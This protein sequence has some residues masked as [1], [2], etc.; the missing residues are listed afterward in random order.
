[1]ISKEKFAAIKLALSENVGPITYRQIISYFKN[2]QAAI[3]NFSDFSSKR[4][5]LIKLASD[6]AVHQQLDMAEKLGAQLLVINTPEYPKLLSHI[7]DAPPILYAFGNT[8]LFERKCIS[9]VGSR[10]AS[11]NGLNLARKIS[12]DLTEAEM[13]VV[14]GMAKGID[15]AAHEGSLHSKINKAGTI[16]VLGTGVDVVYPRENKDIYEEIK[17][18]GLILSEMPF[19]SK[20]ITSAFPR[21][22]RIISGLTLGTLVV[23]ASRMSG[24]LITAREALSQSREVFAIP[25]SPLD[26]RAS[27]PNQLIKDGAHLVSSAEDILSILNSN[28]IL[29][30]ADS[31]ARTSDVGFARLMRNDDEFEKAKQQILNHLSPQV[32]SI[33]S[34]I[35]GTDLDSDLVQAVLI[36]LELSG[37]IERFSGNRIALLY[38]NEWA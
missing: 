16:A 33:T 26:S 5:R 1:M 15:R 12:Y 9:I 18:K 27:G 8:T 23:E 2:A 38:N 32:T 4:R 35:Q 19:G 21:R 11:L 34:I 36:E 17:E 29:S 30:F 25:G 10:N 13:V 31:N 28:T 7:D 20:P 3:D 6:G 14:S 37:K 22:N 24:S